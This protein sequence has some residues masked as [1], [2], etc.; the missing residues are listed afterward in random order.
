[1]GD[2]NSKSSSPDTSESTHRRKWGWALNLLIL[3]LS[4]WAIW[5]S[6]P[7][8]WHHWKLQGT[9]ASAL[10]V[11]DYE[12]RTVSIP[13]AEDQ[14]AILVF[15]ASWCAPCK[16]ELERYRSAVDANEIDP[17]KLYAISIGEPLETVQRI[18]HERNY[19]FRVY[20]DP[21]HHAS[22]PFNVIA[23]PTVVHLDADRTIDW[24]TSGLSP[25]LIWRARRHLGA[26]Y[27]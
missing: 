14:P 20:A 2:L 13:L 3:L 19:P 27:L 9:V 8:W 4:I 23:T 18:A 16:V 21:A 12:G 6:A 5:R 7:T 25:T 15:W 1:M 22:A 26:G 10:H 11:L 17:S 24:I